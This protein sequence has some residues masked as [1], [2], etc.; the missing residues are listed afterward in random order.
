[1]TQVLSDASRP[2]LPTPLST[3]K[4]GPVLKA[5]GLAALLSLGLM[6][7]PK[8]AVAMPALAPLGQAAQA[9][10]SQVEPA[11]TISFSYSTRRHGP[12]YRVVRP[13][14][15]HYYGGYYYRQPYWSPAYVYQRP[16]Y[17]TRPSV[18]FGITVG[19]PR[20]VR[21]GRSAHV[22]WCQ[23]RYRTYDVRTDSFIARVGHPRVRCRSPY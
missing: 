11:G 4:G 13:G 14:Y 22:A 15:R 18:S 6:V 5:M 10:G 19:S 16:V 21:R 1:M 23:D 9:A 17:R 12:R 3:P 8:P 2:A 20:V 7:A